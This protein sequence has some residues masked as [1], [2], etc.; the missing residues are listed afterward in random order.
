MVVYTVGLWV[1]RSQIALETAS[2]YAVP[3]GEGMQSHA[4][5]ILVLFVSLPIFQFILVRW[6][7]RF[8]LWFWFLWRVSRLDLRLVPIHPDRTG[9][10][11]FLGRST[12]AFAPILFAQGAVLAGLLASQIFYAG[13]T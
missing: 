10:L 4:R 5:R 9:G 6:Y 7:L 1:W 8:F 13:T 12:N 11:G 2:W 3:D